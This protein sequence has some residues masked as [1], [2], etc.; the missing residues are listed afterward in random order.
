MYDTGLANACQRGGEHLS[1]QLDVTCS[2]GHARARRPWRRRQLGR[3][4]VVAAWPRFHRAPSSSSQRLAARAPPRLAASGRC[5]LLSPSPASGRTAT[6]PS[7]ASL[8][9]G[10]ASH[11]TPLV[12][13]GT[14]ASAALGAPQRSD[15]RRKAP[16]AT[17]PVR[18]SAA[19][20]ERRGRS[21][22]GA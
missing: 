9:P 1:Q 21:L 3:A 6:L 12:V 5:M 18:T 11:V 14:P 19:T 13:V 22:V 2:Q 16:T 8:S 7:R 20:P 15:G 17:R 10:K 4:H